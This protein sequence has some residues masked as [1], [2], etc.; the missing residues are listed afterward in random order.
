MR[1]WLEKPEWQ[2]TDLQKLVDQHEGHHGLHHGHGARHNA[3]VVA[4][5]C[6]QIHILAIAAHRVLL[7]GDCAG[8]LEGH[9][10]NNVLT[11]GQAPLDAAGSAI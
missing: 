1:R 10:D 11:I 7:D 9:L 5:S 2:E 6:Q 3:G 8:G 4:P